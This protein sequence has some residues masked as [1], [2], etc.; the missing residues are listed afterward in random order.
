[1]VAK[2]REVIG[3]EL[4]VPVFFLA[5]ACLLTGCGSGVVG[6]LAPSPPSTSLCGSPITAQREAPA[7]ASNVPYNGVPFSASVLAGA[8]PI[9]GASL[10][11]YAAGATG[12]GSPA[13]S[14]IATPLTTDAT[15][16]VL[17]PGTF[18]CPDSASMLYLVS[19]GGAV[20]GATANANIVLTVA[21]GSCG[22]IA[23]TS[24]YTLNEATTVAT[25]AALMQFYSPVN[26]FGAS[27]SNLTGLS[28][29]F[30]T[31]AT[32]ADPASGS[33]PGSTLP[34]NAVSPANR[35]DSLANLVNGCVVSQGACASFFNAVAQG[36]T[37][38]TN[39]LDAVY[40]LLRAPANNVAALFAASQASSAYAPALTKA[41]LDWT[42]FVT[43]AGGGLS[44]PSGIGVDSTG[45]VWVASYNFAASK[46]SPIGAPIFPHGL[47]GGGLSD[48]YGLAIDLS[49]NA[50]IPNEPSNGNGFES[51]VSVFTPTGASAAGGGYTAG[52]LNY[53]VS[54]AIDPNGTTWV[55]DY[56][57]SH[58]TLLSSSGQPL[59]GPSGYTTADFAFPIV[60]AVD[61][62]H[63]GWVGN[64]SDKNVIKVAPDGS[65]FTPYNC[66]EGAAGIAFDQSNNAWIANFYG[67]SVS[68]ISC[69]GDIVSNLA[70]TGLGSID[71]PQGIAIDGAGSV[72]VAN[73]R[74]P[75][76]T[77]LSGASS[78]TPG[79]ALS[80]LG[81]LGGD[82][83]LLDAY[84]LA[85]DAS[86]NIW[87]SNQGSSTIT[88]FIGQASPVKTPLSGLPQAP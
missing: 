52:G 59:S 56:G 80:P 32:L 6:G 55:V 10:S 82:A 73:Y 84:A 78:S 28:N 18:A 49:D 39:T 57:D 86:G 60:V 33:V 25:M 22:S 27:S 1:M 65:S 71:H 20:A 35:V 36:S 40:D 15:G 58:V 87:V 17:V 70:Y 16:A 69:K 2:H 37:A 46:F 43:Y 47:H 11:L 83:E 21:L 8:K 81:G 14:L 66:C 9:V 26:G 72:W 23:A 51:S 29:A 44:T 50:W 19:R 13:T 12:N 41:P 62:D 85:L 68:A 74:A 79:S 38:P 75:Y 24:H 77:E 5:A 64:L 76:L 45:S 53:P 42:L 4:W 31:A 88:K 48:S 30:A 7:A 67:A 3:N 61:A 63:F 54:V 34:S